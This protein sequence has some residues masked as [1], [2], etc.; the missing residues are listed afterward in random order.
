M[1]FNNLAKIAQDRKQFVE[2]LKADSHTLDTVANFKVNSRVKSEFERICKDSHS[3]LSRELKLYML[4][5]I[6]RGRL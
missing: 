4:E 1:D 6:K 3:S 5:V 2:E